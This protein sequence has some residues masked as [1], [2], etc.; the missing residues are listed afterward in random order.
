MNLDKLP[1]VL[2]VAQVAAVIRVTPR[3]VRALLER[4]QLPGVCYGHQWI[5][6]RD[7][8]KLALA[9]RE[10]RLA[11]THWAY[12]TMPP[13]EP[14]TSTKTFVHGGRFFRVVRELPAEAGARPR[15]YV[16]VLC[17]GDPKAEQDWA[18][19]AGSFRLESKAVAAARREIQTLARRTAL[20]GIAG[21]R[22]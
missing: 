2:T 14:T 22:A 3:R 7:T 15:F 10:V 17:G 12:R 11:G 5:L 4:G 9:E 8:L 16:D 1:P 21:P 18:R 6:D 20:A 13:P 19:V